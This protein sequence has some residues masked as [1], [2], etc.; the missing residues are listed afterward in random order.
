MSLKNILE[1]IR[2]KN[3]E[4]IQNW[5]QAVLSDEDSSLSQVDILGNTS[6]HKV[7]IDENNISN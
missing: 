1:K 7:S 3:E 2:N 5:L 4:G 6:A